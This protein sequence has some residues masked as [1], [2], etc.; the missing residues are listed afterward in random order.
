MKL[1]IFAM[2][3]VIPC[4]MFNA[5]AEDLKPIPVALDLKPKPAAV[6]SSQFRL[7][8]D[9]I[10]YINLKDTAQCYGLPIPDKNS[11]PLADFY[12]YTC[13]GYNGVT[14]W[15]NWGEDS[16]GQVTLTPYWDP[17]LDCRCV[18][19]DGGLRRNRRTARALRKRCTPSC[20]VLG[21]LVYMKGKRH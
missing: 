7:Y 9:G 5:T 8:D 12:I 2:A 1:N 20:H 11:N 13:P 21:C 17:R 14:C 19:T 16:K 10:T 4:F 3:L 15:V 6:P 18:P